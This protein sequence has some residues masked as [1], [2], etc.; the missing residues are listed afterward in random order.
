MVDSLAIYSA[1]TFSILLLDQFPQLRKMCLEQAH[2]IKLQ[3]LRN[4]FSKFRCFNKMIQFQ[5]LQMD[6]LKTPVISENG[7][8]GLNIFNFIRFFK[9]HLSK[10][11]N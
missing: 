7:S 8:R 11:D 4:R 5:I 9:V 3:A 6:P 2:L 10:G 1:L